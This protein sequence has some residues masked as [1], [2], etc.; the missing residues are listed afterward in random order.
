MTLAPVLAW[1]LS[2]DH[3]VGRAA[4]SVAA[5]A[6]GLFGVLAMWAWRARP[7]TSRSTYRQ[8]ADAA[9]V[10][11][12]LVHRQWEQEAMLR[13]LFSPAPLPVL[14]WD[15]ALPDASDH[16]SL[17][18]DPVSCRADAPQDLADAFLRLPHR[19]L[20][21]LGPAG[22]GKTTFAVLL[23]LALLRDRAPGAPVPVLLSLA[24]F[25]PERHSAHDW[26]TRQITG[27]YPALTD[28]QS[29]GNTAVDDLLAARRVIPVLDG[30]DELPPPSQ[31]HV[32]AALNAAFPAHAPLVLTCRTG[33]YARAVAEAGVLTA[34]AVIEPAP[35]DAAD[36]LASLRLATPPGP[37]QRRW[38]LLA[39]HVAEN[40]QGPAALAL[41]SPLL[42]ALARTVYADARGDPAELTDA[43][44]FPTATAVEQH[45]L[46]ALVPSLYER[47][48]HPRRPARSA[49]RHLACLAHGLSRQGTHDL[50]WWQLH[51]WVPLLERTW[52]RA[53]VWSLAAALAALAGYGLHHA[54]GPRPQLELPGFLL[55][56]GGVAL[57]L[58][59]MQCLAARTAPPAGARPRPLRT[60]ALTALCGALSNALFQ[61][62]VRRTFTCAG[63][64]ETVQH[65]LKHLTVYGLGIFLV[66]HASGPPAPPQAPSRGSL[67]LLHWR[68]RLPRALATVA[69]A[70]VLIGA[71]LNLY[72]LIGIWPS[73]PWTRR[74]AV[75]T[76]AV[77][78]TGVL[79][80]ALFGT[81]LGVVR[82]VR[83]SASRLDVT[84]PADSV[85][86]DR[87]ITLVGAAAAALLFH[88]PDDVALV[89]SLATGRGPTPPLPDIA[90]F[91]LSELLPVG[92][93]LA[94]TAFAWPHYGVARLV[95]A[96]QGR[97]PWRLQAFLA[98]A[99]RLGILRQVGS[100]YQFR[101]ASLQ[102]RLAASA[103]VPRRR[104]RQPGGCAAAPAR[105]QS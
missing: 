12:H 89:M 28:V 38:D 9:E 83:T 63:T 16:R 65:N 34:A 80:G 3:E 20:V 79:T 99:H 64:V 97:L 98:D 32:L 30:L 15:A 52:T 2:E 84:T 21:V 39:G 7:H 27:G 59:T 8:V 44:R 85:R 17:I 61:V 67:T 48:H 55:V 95:L 58:F 22:S 104:G 75:S 10:L 77:W 105:R 72:V 4:G 71:A 51:H 102:H 57:A 41:Q 70:A 74:T 82:A 103:R 23:T 33:A 29:Y 60:A 81:V 42:T 73:D 40:P 35:L 45:L 36:A 47:A 69:G 13:Q 31:P 86:A 46:D 90:L 94:L 76:V 43:R 54:A 56:T 92:V 50:A 88:L 100:V 25:D 53:V 49:L 19:R 1:E 11:A 62:V 68:E 26:L 78:G 66:L 101:H 6:T 5:A 96:A 87:T 37:A 91:A 24:S 14:W 93:V 18:G